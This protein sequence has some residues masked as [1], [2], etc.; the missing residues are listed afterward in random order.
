M[1]LFNEM[2]APGLT[3][4]SIRR[5]F[6]VRWKSGRIGGI[7]FMTTTHSAMVALALTIGLPALALAQAGAPP[8]TTDPQTTPPWAYTLLRPGTV[9]P[10]DD[11]KPHQ[12]PGS[13]VQY[14][15]TQIRDLFNAKDWFPDERRPMP[16]IV[17]RG[18]K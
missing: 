5:H 11:G 14:T 7:E 17:A 1:Q 6:P 10:P 13:S 9:A 15:W 4:S 3:K 2:I 18:R 12:L 16:E 8:V